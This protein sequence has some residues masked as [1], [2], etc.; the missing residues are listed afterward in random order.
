MSRARALDLD[1]IFDPC[2]KLKSEPE[3]EPEPSPSPSPRRV[4]LTGLSQG[5]IGTWGLASDPR[6]VGLFAAIAPVCGGFPDRYTRKHDNKCCMCMYMCTY[7]QR[8][9]SHAAWTSLRPDTRRAHHS[10]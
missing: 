9:E 3:P 7:I 1:P 2:P 8:R 5:G 6:Y 4:Y 10:F